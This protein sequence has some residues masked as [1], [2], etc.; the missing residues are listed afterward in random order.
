M[1]ITTTEDEQNN[2]LENN[3]KTA[4]ELKAELEAKNK[5][6]PVSDNEA[7][8]LKEL[9]KFKERAKE[10]ETARKTLEAKYEGLDVEAAKNALKTAEEAENKELE[11]KGEY[12]RL[13]EK[14]REAGNL[15]IAAEEKARKEAEA[16][17]QELEQTANSLRVNNAF[18]NSKYIKDTLALTANKT[19]ALYASYF[20]MEEGQL[21]PYDAPKGQPGRTKIVNEN[22][23]VVSFDKAMEAII[24]ADPDKD[25]LIKATIKAG[26][27]SKAAANEAT[28]EAKFDNSVDKIAAGVKNPKNFGY[29][30]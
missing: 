8:L 4:E 30:R 18:A 20:E 7:A 6:P 16:K 1:T 10:A 9:M 5:K 2:E 25:Y 24:N 27:Q 28:N 12:E 15:R 21:I 3:G 29:V 22:G 11:R 17:I 26:A 19:Q 23:V 14:Q 13:L